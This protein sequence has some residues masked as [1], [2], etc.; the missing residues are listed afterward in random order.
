MTYGVWI[1]SGTR[2][3][4]LEMR[5][6]PDNNPPLSDTERCFRDT[7]VL[8]FWTGEIANKQD[9]IGY[10]WGSGF[11]APTRDVIRAGGT[12]AI[13]GALWIEEGSSSPVKD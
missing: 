5:E 9:L 10:S 13:I 8:S 6:D 3:I 7:A 12:S 4:D 1:S 2:L 11:A